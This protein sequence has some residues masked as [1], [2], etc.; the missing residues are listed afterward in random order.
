MPDPKNPTIESW[1]GHL[2]KIV[3]VPDEDTYF[4]GHSIGCQAIL[5]YVEQLQ[6][7]VG[8][9]ICVAGFLNSL[10]LDDGG[11]EKIAKPWLET[12]LNYE[13]IKKG[14]GKI[15]AIFSDNDESVGLEN[16]NLFEKYLNARTI[17]EHDKGHFSDDAGIK[18]MPSALKAI[19]EISDR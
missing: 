13:E 16:K 11:K 15:I 7:P 8:G 14:S 9:V 19:L 17:L 10:N 18:E 3:G 12:P 4:V 1:V 2:S 5:R 6:K